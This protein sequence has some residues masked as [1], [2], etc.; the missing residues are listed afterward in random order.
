MAVSAQTAPP[1]A[2]SAA[3]PQLDPGSHR[4]RR[5]AWDAAG[6]FAGLAT[7]FWVFVLFLYDPGLVVDELED[8][9]FPRVA[10]R[11]CSAAIEQL[12]ALPRAETA[13][14]ATERAATIEEANAILVEMVDELEP[15]APGEP[16]SATEA[17]N[18]WI[19]DWRN[20]IE[21]RQQF[22]ARLREDASARF[23]ESPKGSKQLSRAIDGYAQVNRMRS[24]E[25]PGDIG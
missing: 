10:E 20:H 18:E 23:T 17:V 14:S 1:S 19:S 11:I 21:D 2:P 25:T 9:S 7:G 12:D 16:A 13:G 15:L 3:E 4:R 6:I 5:L 24:C 8:R 22:A